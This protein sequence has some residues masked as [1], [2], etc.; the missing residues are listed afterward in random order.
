MHSAIPSIHLQLLK[1]A[2]KAANYSQLSYSTTKV[3]AEKRVINFILNMSER[4]RQRGYIHTEFILLL[5]R[6]EIGNLLNLS[7]ETISLCL[8][9][10]KRDAYIDIENKRHILIKGINKLQAFLQDH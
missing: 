6:S 10:L 1:H 4:Y 2:C 3:C 5:S 8:R 9:K 7:A